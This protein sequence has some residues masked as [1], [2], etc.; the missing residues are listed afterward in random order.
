MITNLKSV[1]LRMIKFRIKIL[2]FIPL[3]K[4]DFIIIIVTYKK[5]IHADKLERK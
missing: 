2:E 4:S 3:Q 1:E 5:K